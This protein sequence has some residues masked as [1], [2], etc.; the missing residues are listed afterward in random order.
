MALEVLL[1]MYVYAMVGKHGHRGP[2]G[3][4]RLRVYGA[5]VVM[6]V[7]AMV[8]KHGLRGPGG[9][10]RLRVYGA[11]MVMHSNKIHAK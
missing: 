1:G 7:Y 9:H 6:H 3:F 2:G 8:G 10:A 5:C 11:C 4:A